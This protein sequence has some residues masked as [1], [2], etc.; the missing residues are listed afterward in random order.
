MS[1]I[2][3]KGRPVPFARPGRRA[4]GR[5]YT[6]KAYAGWKRL[7]AST[8]SLGLARRQ[9]EKVET[10]PVKATIVVRSEGVTIELE[11]SARIRPKYVRGDLDNYLKAALD[12]AQ[13]AGWISDDRQV[14]EIAVVFDPNG[15]NT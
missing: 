2:E 6:P 4:D 15:G 7:A 1:E 13:D 5:R 9:I 14:V 11:P 10:G 12:A 8:M 3:I